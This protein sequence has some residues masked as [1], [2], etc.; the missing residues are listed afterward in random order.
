MNK[1]TALM[2]NTAIFAIGTFSS[3]IL[4][5]IMVFFYSRAM[6]TAEFG[7]LDIIIN[8]G[9]LL[10]PVAM[11]GI[12]N[13][14]IR[15][16]VD[17][18]FKKSDVFTSGIIAVALGFG[19]LLLG[20]PLLWGIKDLRQYMLILYLHILASSLRH[21]CSFFVRANGKLRLFAVDGV[22]TTFMTCLLTII[23]LIPLRMGII[24]YMLAI[25][26]AD[27]SSV[28][29]LCVMGKL[30]QF[31]D[32]KGFNK[33]LA[34]RMLRFSLPLIP[35]SLLWWIVNVSDRYFIK[36][37][38]DDAANGLYAAAY[39]V[40][41]ILSLV[42]H[43]F[44]DAWQLSAVSENK[45]ADRNRFYSNI[46][47]TFSG[48]VFVVGSGIIVFSKF[49]TYIL[50]DSSY[51][52][53]WQYIPALLLSTVFSSLVIFLGNIYIAQSRSVA[54]LITTVIG[55]LLNIVLNFFLI[56]SMGAQGAAIATCVSYFA[57][58]ITRAV[59]IRRHSPDISFSPVFM[60]ANTALIAAQALLMV[61]EPPY[62]IIWQILLFCGIFALN[63]R[64]MLSM[65]KKVLKRN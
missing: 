45:A 27:I 55:A 36:F 13:A 25:I 3:K 54:S 40:P 14:I 62:W 4:S 30:P 17:N 63:I 43:M 7:M 46:F 42:A 12:T 26:L 18:D 29:F 41:T 9:S 33:S 59:D 1:Y 57:V 52:S 22:F 60:A 21:I 47:K 8:T 44:L 2:K 38:I 23:F 39:K 50:L 16:G 24:G 6:N 48:C 34:R 31:I 5:F 53:S 37:M 32:F 65:A 58:F 35:T 28:I 15:F 11:L 61:L 64:S 10:L 20:L 19:V 49:V 51:Y 56:R